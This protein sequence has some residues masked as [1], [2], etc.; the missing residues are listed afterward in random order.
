MAHGP[1]SQPANRPRAPET[2][3]ASAHTVESTRARILRVANQLLFRKGFQRTH[4]QEIADELGLTAPA[5]YR[6]FPSKEALC[7]EVLRTELDALLALLDEGVNGAG[8]V[9]Q[10]LRRVIEEMVL[11]NLKR[12]WARPGGVTH[13]PLQLRQALGLE[14]GR[15]IDRM[16]REVIGGIRDILESGR[17]AGAFRFDDAR[18]ATFAMLAALENSG[19]WARPDG[20]LSADEIARQYGDLVLAM[21]AARPRRR[22]SP[23]R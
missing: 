11:I 16:V 20:E 5:V 2:D 19:A 8:R 14:H 18:V 3:G 13:T 7:F 4:L 6:H 12:S 23:A 21:V 10:R 1:A 9:D 22:R 17:A 15:T